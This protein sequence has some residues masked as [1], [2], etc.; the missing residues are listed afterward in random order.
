MALKEDVENDVKKIFKDTWTVRD[1]KVIPDD[2]SVT[3]GNDGVRIQ[4]T[5]LYADLAKSTQT[6]K[7]NL[8]TTSA[9]IYK[10]FL[11]ST[12]KVIRANGGVITSFDG[13]RVMSV[14]MGNT[15]NTNAT[16]TAL[17]VNY[18]ILKIVQPAFEL[19]YKDSKYKFEFG[20]GVDTSSTLV[21]KTG[22]EEQMTLYG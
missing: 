11:V 12:C 20:I 3:L 5:V 1:G 2:S 17:Q 4:A 15:S 18:T 7:N 10:A 6:V 13:D 9:E 19:Q 8:D 22:I 21:A 14:F 16:K